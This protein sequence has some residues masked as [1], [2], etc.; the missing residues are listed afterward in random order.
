MGF[1]HISGGNPNKTWEDTWKKTSTATPLCSQTAWTSR[2]QTE[3]EDMRCRCLATERNIW[4]DSSRLHYTPNKKNMVFS[5]EYRLKDDVLFPKKGVIVSLLASILYSLGGARVFWDCNLTP[6]R[7]IETNSCQ[8]YRE[9]T[10]QFRFG[11]DRSSS[12]DFLRLCFLVF[13]CGM[14]WVDRIS[15]PPWNLL[16]NVPENRP[17]LPQKEM[18]HLPIPWEFSRVS[19]GVKLPGFFLLQQTTETEDWWFFSGHPLIILDSVDSES[20]QVVCFFVSFRDKA[21]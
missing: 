8:N 16:K 7:G 12:R 21:R 10:D 4:G 14:G 13:S 17:N 18:N 20:F 6:S 1:K 5:N 11:H 15:F 19:F 3:V 2:S 9:A